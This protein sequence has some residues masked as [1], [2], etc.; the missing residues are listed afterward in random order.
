METNID[1]V[2]T[3]FTEEKIESIFFIIVGVISIFLAFI[4][5][6]IIKYSL[7]NGFAYPLLIIGII[8]LTV[9]T[10]IFVRSPKDIA[11]VEQMIK[12]T[13]EKIKSEELPR[14]NNVM[15]SFE[16]YQWI[17]IAFIII[18]LI[19]YIYFYSSSQTFW[20]G[21]G[22][23][24]LIQGSLMLSLDLIAKDRAI[25]YVDQLTKISH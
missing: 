16:T 18:G 24:L 6:F 7:Y 21:L 2:K 15:K 10:V 11:R 3:Y 1:F 5:W 4:F 19:L 23:G 9:G 13:P 8:Q 14:M 25:K 22:F 12:D 17:E 20:K